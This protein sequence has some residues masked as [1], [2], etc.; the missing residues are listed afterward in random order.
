[1]A[2]LRTAKFDLTGFLFYLA[3]EDFEPLIKA[4]PELQYARV[5]TNGGQ[6]FFRCDEKPFDD[7]NVRRALSMAIDYQTIKDLYYGGQA[8]ILAWP[9]AP[10]LEYKDSYIPLEQLPES[11]REL[12]EYKPEKAEQLLDEAGYPGP[13][14][15]S[16]SC[17]CTTEATIDL[18]SIVKNDLA[19]IGVTL[20]IDVRMGAVFSTMQA[21]KSYH[22]SIG[23]V[24]WSNVVRDNFKVPEIQCGTGRNGGFCDQY[25]DDLLTEIWAY[26]NVGKSDLQQQL[27]KELT[28]YV[29]PLAVM[30]QLPS[31]YQYR[32]WWPWVKNFHGEPSVTYFTTNDFVRYIWIDQDLKEQMTGRR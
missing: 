15:F 21:A 9:T 27:K 29:L 7:V 3:E 23:G 22:G 16:F 5:L 20:N 30:V 13:N 32:L 4:H 12:F 2:A 18:L 6:V 26:E 10:I 25:V 14:R 31:P 28:A 11:T 8:E 17:L 19:K 1:V 24:L